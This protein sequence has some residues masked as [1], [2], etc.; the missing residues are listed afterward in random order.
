M[1]ILII[2][3]IILIKY[4]PAYEVSIA[5]ETVG[6]VSSREE[7]EENVSTF[8][9]DTTG[10][11]AFV[12]VVDMPQ[13][14][15]K[16]LSKDQQTSE[17]DILSTIKNNANITYKTYAISVDGE[18]KAEVESEEEANNIIANIKQNTQEGV[19]VDFGINAEYSSKFDVNTQE[20]AVATLNGIKDQKVA[21]YNEAKRKEAE[22]A[23]AAARNAAAAAYSNSSYTP[24]A[25]LA[26]AGNIGNLNLQAPVSGM[27]SSRFGDRSGVRRYTHTGTD[28]AAPMGTAVKAST[29]GTV[30]FAGWKGSYGN[31]I[32]ID[33]ANGVQT[34]YGHLS[35]IGVSVGQQVNSSTVIGNV[36][37]TGNST[38]PHLHFEIRINGTPVNPQNYL[39]K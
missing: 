38:G 16:L 3:T 39:Y 26:S 31:C 35:K 37:S 32:I 12:E 27:I 30:S 25:V 5:G 23:A 7:M 21:E 19:N 15:Y 18:K 28:I 34:W 24:T 13:Y 1:A 4:K 29:A 2:S 11:V 10:N 9:N 14:E 22:A 36:G 8:I 6:F 17:E 33:H 20:E